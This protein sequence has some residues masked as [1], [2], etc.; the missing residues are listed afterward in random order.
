MS[1][2]TIERSAQPA[3]AI[4]QQARTN[5]YYSFLFLPRHKREAIENIYAFCRLVD[6]IVDEDHKVDDPRLELALWH[7]EVAEC[8]SGSPFTHLG[9][10]LK[11]LVAHFPIPQRY[12]EELIQGMEMDLEKCRYENFDELKRYCYYVAGVIGLMCIEI[13]GYK[14]ASTRDYAVKLGTALQLVNILRDLREDADRFRVYL[15]QEEMERFGYSEAELLKSVYNDNFIAL[16]KFQC[17]RA[18]SYFEQARV[19]LSGEDRPKMVAAEIMG[20]IY[21]RLLE[22]IEAANYNVFDFRIRLSKIEKAMIAIKT[23]MQF[24]FN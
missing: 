18:R 23:W 16:M 3:E 2:T 20:Q 10:R 24:R 21:Y 14:N 9:K 4:S 19:T 1:K 5:F 6:D 15:P 8:F 7:R 22:K 12:F 17:S 13:F 11:G